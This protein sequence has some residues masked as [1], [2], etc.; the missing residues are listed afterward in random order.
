MSANGTV[1]GKRL[2]IEHTQFLRKLYLYGSL[3]KELTFATKV[4]RLRADSEEMN[5]QTVN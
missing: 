1:K 3:H 2:D 5:F 4:Q